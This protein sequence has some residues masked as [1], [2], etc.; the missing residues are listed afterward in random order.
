MMLRSLALLCLFFLS[1]LLFSGCVQHTSRSSLSVPTN[2]IIEPVKDSSHVVR[3]APL[4]LPASVAILMAPSEN[5][6]RGIPFT[7]L[8]KAADAFKQQLLANPKYVKSVKVVAEDPTRDKISLDKIRM[9]YGTDIAVLLSYRQDQRSDQSGWAGFMDMTIIGA[10]LVP[11]VKTITSSVI[12]GNVIHI[13]SNAIIFRASGSDERSIHSTSFGHDG[14]AVEESINS[15]LAATTDF[16]NSLVGTLSRFDN[17]D[18]SHAL[19][20]SVLTE[21]DSAEAATYKPANDY[22]EKVG[23][24]KSTGGGA[25][26]A[27][28]LLISA[29]ICCGAWRFK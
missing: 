21:G 1:C 22:W 9:V 27:V 2:K 26:D 15:F 7:T 29:V 8:R 20:V 18:F 16:G 17:Y 12:D 28:F 13:P 10:F 4:S 23:S 6:S 19:P 11:G 14:A 25:F 5:P 3:K 24:F